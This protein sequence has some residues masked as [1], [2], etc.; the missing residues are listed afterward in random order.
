MITE[1]PEAIGKPTNLEHL[2]V[3]GNK[4][5]AMPDEC[6]ELVSLRRLDCRRNKIRDITVIGTLLRLEKLSAD[7]NPLHALS[8][9]VGSQVTTIDDTHNEITGLT[10]APDSGLRPYKLCSLDISHGR[11]SSLDEG[12]KVL[13]ESLGSLRCLE[14][15]SRADNQLVGLRSCKSFNASSNLLAL[16]QYPSAIR[17]SLAVAEDARHPPERKGSASSLNTS[18]R[19][20]PLAHSLEKLYL[21]ENQFTDELLMPI[22]ILKELRVLNLSFN[23][24]QDLPINFFR[25]FLKLEELYLSGNK[26]ASIPTEDLPKLTKL[27]A[28]FLNGNKL[29]TLPRELGKV[30]GLTIL[31][32]G[33]NMLKN[34]NT[35]L[36]YLNLSGNK[37]L[38]IK[39]DMKLSGNRHSRIRAPVLRPQ[40][41]LAG[42][43]GLTQLLVLGLTDVTITPAGT[44]GS[45]DIPDENEE[46]RV[47]TL[48]STVMG[49]TYGIA[50]T[51]GE[52]RTIEH[53]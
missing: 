11:L 15:L 38:Q 17:P 52:E 28:L 26:L 12:F 23:D 49:M 47:R 10:L 44:N 7:H 18:T 51:L 14:S 2:I 53:A 42:F 43:T 1:L 35:N 9:C 21:G 30:I 31:D 48:D 34:F 3:T 45:I 13:P 50:D 41:S 39:S 36:K 16:W 27:T 20:L 8:L 24:I 32:V 40:P 6:T 33:S 29:Q 4:R 19:A 5:T 37:R 25:N 46:R 22:T